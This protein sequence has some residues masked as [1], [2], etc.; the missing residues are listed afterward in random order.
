MAKSIFKNKKKE[1]LRIVH[2]QLVIP[3]EAP[4]RVNSVL[5]LFMHIM[6]KVQG[7]LCYK[8]GMKQ[9]MLSVYH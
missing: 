1:C 4:V 7:S 3:P 8:P 9:V 5:C 2:L 6:L